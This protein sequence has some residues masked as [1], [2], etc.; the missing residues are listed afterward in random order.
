MKFLD[1]LELSVGS[2]LDRKVLTAL[3]IVGVLIGSAMILTLEATSAGTTSGVEA[4][5]EKVGANTLIVRAGGANFLSGSQ[6]SYQLTSQDVTALSHLSNIANVIPYYSRQV[7][8]SVGGKTVSGTMIGI[9]P[10]QLSKIYKGLTLAEGAFPTSYD[11]TAAVVGYDVAYPD[12]SGTQLVGLN[13][14]VSMK[15]SSMGSKSSTTLSFLVTGILTQ[16]GSA[17]F[18][19]IDSDVF[20]SFNAAQM[21]LGSPYFSAIYVIV[22]NV[23][24]VS[25]VQT[26]IESLYASNEITVMSAG[27]IASSLSSVSSQLSTTFGDIGSV[28]LIVAAVIVTCTMYMTIEKRT[29]EIGVLK[30]LGFQRTQILTMF[31]TECAI[32]GVAGGILGTLV[33]IIASYSIGGLFSF[34]P[35]GGGP[36][37]GTTSTSATTPVF[38]AQLFAIALLLPVIVSIGAGFYPA[39]KGARMKPVDAL[40]YE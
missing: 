2:L 28:S 36:G 15:I 12:S 10:Q 22:D 24:D 33:G 35:G 30:A 20:V 19:D 4:Q 13:Q 8:I 38:T 39:W 29:R 11:P 17:L 40:K 3:T 37:R 18:N 27:S 31:L 32:I 14:A 1:I 7:D 34:G 25:A 26:A 21:L 6:S 5:V 16:Y 9:D 23:N